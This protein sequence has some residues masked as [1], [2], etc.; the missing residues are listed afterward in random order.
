MRRI[1]PD[2]TKLVFAFIHEPFANIMSCSNP[3]SSGS[4]LDPYS[5]HL[6]AKCTTVILSFPI[7][8]FS[9]SA[10]SPWRPG[11]RQFREFP[12]NKNSL[13]DLWLY[14]RVPDPVPLPA[15]LKRKPARE[16]SL[17]QG[18]NHEKKVHVRR[19]LRWPA[20]W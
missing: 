7:P 14:L 8:P 20:L 2:V 6:K 18:Q 11:Y 5:H 13:L 19:W 16:M 1:D 17:Q 4:L 12:D 9:L 15:S 10:L 3:L